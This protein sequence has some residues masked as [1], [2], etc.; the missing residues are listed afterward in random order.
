MNRAGRGLLTCTVLVAVLTACSSGG[1]DPPPTSSTSQVSSTSTQAT[2]T[3]SGPN[4][5]QM[6]ET[7]PPVAS[8][9]W[10]QQARREAITAAEEVLT[11][12]ARPDISQG[13]WWRDLGPMMTPSARQVYNSVDVAEV[14]VREVKGKGRITDDSSPYLAT[15]EINTDRGKYTVLMARTGQGAPWLAERIEPER[16]S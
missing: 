10:D 14:P 13:E 4:D 15:V 6:T 16:D 2:P 12:F 5:A 11:A 8:P 9:T 7:T 1:E 3:P